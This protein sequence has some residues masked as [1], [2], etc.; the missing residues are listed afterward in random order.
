VGYNVQSVVDD[1]HGLIVHAEAVNESND[2]HQF[3]VQIDQ[4]NEVL[5][6]C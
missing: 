6:G 1:R 5:A 4:A 3:R 2:V